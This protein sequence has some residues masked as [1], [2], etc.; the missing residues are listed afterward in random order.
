[1]GKREREEGSG[2]EGEGEKREEGPGKIV[3]VNSMGIANRSTDF[4]SRGPLCSILSRALT[5]HYGEGTK[6]GHR[7][8]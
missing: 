2:E 7:E 4:R 6:E 3:Q 1:M 5:G 8:E